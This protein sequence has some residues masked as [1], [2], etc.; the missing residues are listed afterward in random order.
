[1][2]SRVPWTILN[3]SLSLIALL[4]LLNLFNVQLPSVGR[5]LYALDREEPRCRIHWQEAETLWNDLD[6]CCLEARAQLRC[7]K[8]TTGDKNWVCE[9]A[10]S[11]V[12][13]HLNNKAYRYCAQQP[14]W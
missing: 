13:Y 3:I 14:Y 9:T 8:E 6:R 2:A 7:R 10:N 4:L 12:S 1:M 5:A 11:V